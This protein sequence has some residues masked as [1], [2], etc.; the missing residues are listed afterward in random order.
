MQSKTGV[1]LVFGKISSGGTI[2]ADEIDELLN[3][4][5]KKSDDADALKSSGVDFSKSETD[6][7]LDT[8][9]ERGY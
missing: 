2:S 9:S 8:W 5:N 3:A 7:E 1:E 6:S 4:E